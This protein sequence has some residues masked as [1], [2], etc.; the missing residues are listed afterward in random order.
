[1]RDVVRESAI[2]RA[3]AG[4]RFF[5]AS[6]AT[7]PGSGLGLAIARSI[8]QRHG[9]ELRLGAGADGRGLAVSIM[10]PLL[11]DLA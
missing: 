8:T 7:Q 3:R 11:A 9:G 10:L 2:E 4:E 1:M 5:R 6:N